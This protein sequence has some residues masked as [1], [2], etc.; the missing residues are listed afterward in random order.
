MSNAAQTQ[1]R[2]DRERVHSARPSWQGRNYLD[3]R[4]REKRTVDSTVEA[5]PIGDMSQGWRGVPSP[6]QDSTGAEDRA[7]G[8][9]RRMVLPMALTVVLAL[10]S[11]LAWVLV[12]TLVRGDANLMPFF[13]DRLFIFLIVVGGMGYTVWDRANDTDYDHTHAGVDRLRL[14]TMRDVRIAELQAETQ[15]RQAALAMSL[16]LLESRDNDGTN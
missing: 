1:Y 7:R 12:V 2:Q 6:S 15:Q 14:E 9:N 16:K 10:V 13:I 11:V 8:F 4:P 3:V 5:I